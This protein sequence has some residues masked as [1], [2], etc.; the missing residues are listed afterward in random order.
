MRENQQNTILD[1][2]GVL[3][4]VV[5]AYAPQVGGD[6]EEKEEFWEKLDEAVALIPK[7]ERLIIGSDFNGHVGEGSNGDRKVLGKYGYGARNDEGQTIVDFAHRTDMAVI[8]TYYSK[9]ESHNVTYTSGG[10]HTQIDYILCRIMHLKEGRDCKVIPGESVAK[11]HHVVIGKMRPMSRRRREMKWEEDNTWV[12]SS[13]VLRETAKEL[14]GVT[15]GKK[16]DKETWWW[17][18]EAQEAI[19]RKK[20]AWKEWH[21]RIDLRSKFLY[22]EAKNKAKV[23]VAIAKKEASEEI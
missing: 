10:R 12:D 20:E 1:R 3:L 9:R 15:T 13:N 23:V 22:K 18:K 5:S 16:K 19:A 4:N 6:R 11:Q 14:L 8:K 21:K 7:E 17:N 2:L